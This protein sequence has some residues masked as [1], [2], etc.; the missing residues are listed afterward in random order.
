M[1][2]P[3][4]VTEANP[5]LDVPSSGLGRRR[6]FKGRRLDT[7]CPIPVPPMPTTP[8]PEPRTSSWTRSLRRQPRYTDLNTASPICRS[9]TFPLSNDRRPP[10]SLPHSALLAEGSI[11][12]DNAPGTESGRKSTT[13]FGSPTAFAFPL[14]PC[15]TFTKRCAPLGSLRH[16]ALLAEGCIVNEDAEGAEGERKSTTPSGSPTAFAFPLPPRATFTKRCAPLGV[17]NGPA[18][19]IFMVEAE[20]GVEPLSIMKRASGVTVH[21]SVPG[22]PRTVEPVMDELFSFLDDVYVDYHGPEGVSVVSI[23]LSDSDSDS[24]YPDHP[25]SAKGDD[26]DPDDTSEDLGREVAWRTTYSLTDEYAPFFSQTLFAGILFAAPR[27]TR[28]CPYSFLVER[29]LSLSKYHVQGSRS[30]PDL[31]LSRD[32]AACV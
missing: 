27:E 31:A 4:T 32:V 21:E 10:P 18:P 2:P 14:P 19:E 5:F 3:P 6:N 26:A 24:E 8:P 17:P 30:L 25:G 28:P 22:S 23:S 11:A 20:D 1:G 29:T 16:S 13:P 9:R 12:S 7:S 15:V